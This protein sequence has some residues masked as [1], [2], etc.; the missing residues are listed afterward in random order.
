VLCGDERIEDLCPACLAEQP[1]AQGTFEATRARYDAEAQTFTAALESET[2][3]RTRVRYPTAVALHVRGQCGADGFTLRPVSVTA[4]GDEIIDITG[5][6]ALDDDVSGLLD[7][8]A[9]LT[10]EAYEGDHEL[11]VVGHHGG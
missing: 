5:D 6:A 11:N 10:G 9:E 8:L 7:W 2:V 1:P 3:R 4:A